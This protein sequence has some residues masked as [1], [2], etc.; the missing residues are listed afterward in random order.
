MFKIIFLSAY[1]S[2]I[3]NKNISIINLAGLVIGIASFL[4]TVHYLLFE[5]SYDKFIPKY[6]NVYRV[7]HKVM[8][9]EELIYN[10]A[11]TPPRLFLAAKS[12]V[13][14][15]EA[16]ANAYFE[17]C[18]TLYKE[19]SLTNQDILW[20]SE[21]FERVFPLDM[22]KGIAD[23]SAGYK[24]IISNV[25]A[26]ALFG[27]EDPIG[28]IMMVNEGMPIEITGIF[29]RLPDNTHLTANYFVSVKTWEEMGFVPRD[30]NWTWNSWWN[31]VRLKDGSSKEQAESTI[32]N[33]AD[34]Y[35]TFLKE[36]DRV[37]SFTLQALSDLHFISGID[38]EMGA[39]TNYSSLVNLII[40]AFITL[41]IAWINYVN[42]STAHAQSR[43]LQI[44]MRKLIG[45]TN[46]HLWHQSLVESIM[47]NVSAILLSLMIY[48]VFLKGFAH[49][50]NLPL[51]HGDVPFTYILLVLLATVV[52]GVL[53]SSIYQGIEL[54]K[55]KFMANQNIKKRGQFKKTLII[56]QMSLSIIFLICTII[57]Y[58]Q[59]SFMKNKDLGMQLN[60]VIVCSGPASLN[61][62]GAKR[63][64]FESFRDE[65]LT[66]SDFEA[67]TFMGFVPGLEPRY[68]FTELINPNS[69]VEPDRRFFENGSGYQFIN[70]YQLRLLAGNTFS[71]NADDNNNSIIINETSSKLLGFNTPEEA[72]GKR[73]FHKD[74][75]E[76]ELRIVG[77]VADHHNEGLQKPIYPMVWNNV[78]PFEF[79]YFAIRVNSKNVK[80]A[81]QN[82][83]AIWAKHYPKDNI[84]FEFANEQFNKQYES[85]ARFSKFYLWLTLLSIGISTMGLYGLI[86]FYLEK[87]NKE[88]GIRK[89]NGATIMEVIIMINKDF[90]IWVAIAFVVACPVAYYAMST[91][92][93]HFAYKID[94]SW[95]YFIVS[96]MAI[97]GIAVLTVS[98]LAWKA[99]NRNPV[100]ALRYE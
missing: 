40:I 38:G 13:P 31:Y 86:V 59:I 6:E 51:R 98:V 22:L 74:N 92:L 57:A 8:K 5:F 2:L 50:F 60:D 64:R 44:S 75:N 29:K 24:G 34:K 72:I 45:G 69:G 42:L 56:A 15:V 52:V 78:Y 66:Y 39:T 9:G 3:K 33:F 85:E 19:T 49:T 82:L 68:G 41:F 25:H 35:M 61:S 81:V 87:R 88:I 94:L 65:L 1:R 30:G 54:T 91:W 63:Q 18:L 14:E 4:F 73:V 55:F 80:N 67:A 96:G 53:F 12:D 62:D 79:G 7:N 16:S 58:Q 37:G 83:R 26:K 20:V 84:D 100:E 10:G 70:T 28:K 47:L 46:M 17:K 36:D 71:R 97:L 32:N 95:I 11:K 23:Y 43:S 90:A 77:V 21:G 99:A 76:Q 89:V 93:D 48:V 27:N